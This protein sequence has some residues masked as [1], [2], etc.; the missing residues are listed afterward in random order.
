MTGVEV[1]T[2]QQ[3][4]RPL[5]RLPVPAVAAVPPFKHTTMNA[6]FRAVRAGDPSRYFQLNH[7]R[8]PKGIGYFANIGFDPK[9]AALA[10]P[11]PHRFR[12]DR[13]LQRLR[14]RAARARRA[15]PARLLGAPQLRL[16]LH[17][18]GQQRL[19]PHPVPLGGLPAHDGHRR[20]DAAR[21]TATRRSIR[22][23]SSR[24]SRRG[25]PRSR[26][27]PIIELEL[28]GA[29]PGD[30]VVTTDGRVRGHL[31]VRAAPWVDVTR[32][33]IVVGGQRSCRP[34]TSRA[35]DPRARR[36]AGHARTRPGAHDPLRPRHRGRRSAPTTA[37]SRSSSRGD[38]AHGRRAALHARPAAGVHEPRLR[39]ASRPCRPTAVP[40]R[41]GR[42]TVPRALKP[43][44]EACAR[45]PLRRCEWRRVRGDVGPMNAASV[46]IACSNASGR[47]AWRR[48]SRPRATAS[49]ASRRSSS[50]SASCPSWRAARSSS[51]C[52]S[53]RPSSRCASRTR[54][55][56]RSSTSASPRGDATEHGREAAATPTTWRWS[57]CTG[58]TS[59]ALLARSRRQQHRAPHRAR[60]LR[61]LRG[62]QGARPRAPPAR[63][64]DAPARHRAP[65]R[66]AAERPPVVRGRGE[67][68]RLRHRQGARRAR[69]AGCEDTRTPQA[70]GQVRLHEPRAGARRE[71]RRAQ[72]PL[73]ARHRPLRV[74]RRA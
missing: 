29:H 39:R 14:R 6:I 54:T 64:A 48:S 3:G 9:R 44:T 21:A 1:T 62:R 23:S 11:Q 70:P 2:L 61:R 41:P 26:A 35:P 50:S 46:A 5:R 58:S 73:L 19:A 25:T 28:A 12:R 71:R 60:R 10:H 42:P 47:A 40:R 36:R 13:G 24:T 7:P 38:R 59:R 74:R 27:G 4:L 43:A 63:R 52:S 8:L 72:R 66:V 18:H 49:R 55:S 51:T 37:G 67:G 56:C 33:E 68:H 31:R 34:S 65:R 69:A 15:G 20:P 22:S 17:G 30:E 32:V 53:T 57:T 16:A 45:S